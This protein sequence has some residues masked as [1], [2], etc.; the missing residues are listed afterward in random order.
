MTTNLP[1]FHWLIHCT[2]NYSLY[3]SCTLLSISVDS[4]VTDRTHTHFVYPFIPSACTECNN[5]LLFSG[6]S[7]IPLCYIPFP[8]TFFHQLVFHPPSLHLTIYFLVY[9]SAL[10][11]NSYIR[12]YFKKYPHFFFCRVLV[13]VRLLK[14]G[15]TVHHI[16]I[17]WPWLWL[18]SI[19]SVWVAIEW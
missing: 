16:L 11:P 6:A 17:V 13:S 14:L 3:F 9:L 7:S 4:Y 12:R 8:S 2:H 19:L 18:I 1:F 15:S 10:F 5:S